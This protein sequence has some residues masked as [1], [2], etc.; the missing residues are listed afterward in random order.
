MVHLTEDFRKFKNGQFSISMNYGYR[1]CSSVL[2]LDAGVSSVQ[3][4]LVPKVQ[5][6]S[7]ANKLYSTRLKV[8]DSRSNAVAT[9]LDI[10]DGTA[11]MDVAG[12]I[13]AGFNALVVVFPDNRKVTLY[14]SS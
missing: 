4:H 5:P 2:Y 8:L 6:G 3:F 12:L 10:V 1:V 14:L 9:E 11:E 13:S 7:K